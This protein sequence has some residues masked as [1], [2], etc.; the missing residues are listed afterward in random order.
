MKQ[1]FT[2]KIFWWRTFVCSSLIF[3]AIFGSVGCFCTIWTLEG[4]LQE[5]S[6]DQTARLFESLLERNL[7]N[8]ILTLKTVSTI[9]SSACYSASLWPNCSIPVE[10]FGNISLP[11]IAMTSV[12]T[13]SF[14]PVVAN[15]SFHEFESFAYRFYEEQGYDDIGISS[16]GKGIYFKNL[17][18]AHPDL[19]DRVTNTYGRAHGFALP[20]LMT[21]NIDE[22]AASIMLDIYAEP[23]RA[24]A[25]NRLVDCVGMNKQYCVSSTGIV[26]LVIDIEF[27]P[28]TVIYY[29]ISPFL[30]KSTLVG[31]VS[32]A[33][34]WDTLFSNMPPSVDGL[35][36]ILITPTEKYTFTLNHGNAKFIGMGDR[37][38][39]KYFKYSRTLSLNTGIGDTSYSIELY[40]NYKFVQTHRTGS[41]FVA[42]VVSFLAIC[43][44]SCF[45]FVYDYFVTKERN[46]VME[47][48]R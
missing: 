8:S 1:V 19:R 41:P 6:Y 29:P 33:I 20:I 15:T 42:L 44:S 25:I 18:S 23:V 31:V 2:R 14:A 11:L 3:L 9:F 32:T 7:E 4:K 39:K 10:I 34:N 22:S 12:R 45:F 16:F 21:G 36:C 47:N 48:K 37:H 17:S 46:L 24:V 35:Q 5:D 27:R 40:P 13:I 38:N 43:I 28:A 30:D 26:Q